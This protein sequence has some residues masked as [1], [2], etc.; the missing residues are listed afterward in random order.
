MPVSSTS[1]YIVLN[2]RTIMKQETKNT[3]EQ[4]IDEIF[5]MFS[6]IEQERDKIS[7][8]DGILPIQVELT[9]SDNLTVEKPAVALLKNY[10]SGCTEEEVRKLLTVYYIGRD[11]DKNISGIY[12]DTKYRFPTKAMIVKHLT[13]IRT[14]RVRDNVSKGMNII[15][16]LK[17]DIEESFV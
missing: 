9:T 14:G 11:N 7:K 3:I 17:V 4:I 6:E 1:Y 13:N 12:Q 2:G 10:L 8:E 16:K 15:E 5:A